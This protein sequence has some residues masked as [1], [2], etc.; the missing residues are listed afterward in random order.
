MGAD[1]EWYVD[2]VL[3]GVAGYAVP[4]TDV[5]ERLT[6]RPATTFARWA[7]RH[8]RAVVG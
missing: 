1:A 6:G 5:V 8:A 3:G 4:A 2:S 7:D